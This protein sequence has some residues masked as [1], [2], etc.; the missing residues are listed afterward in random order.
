MQ[1]SQVKKLIR[2]TGNTNTS[3]K[4]YA[5]EKQKMGNI[6]SREKDRSNKITVTDKT[7]R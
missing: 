3:N 6:K 7:E 5:K 2:L 1:V 4:S